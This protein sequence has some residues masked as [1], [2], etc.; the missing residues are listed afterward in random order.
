MLVALASLS[1]SS[2]AD[3]Q[4]DFS[5]SNGNPNGA[6]SYGT[7]SS[8]GGSFTAFTWTQTS[9]LGSANFDGWYAGPN[10]LPG[11]YKLLSGDIFGANG[12]D[13]FIAVGEVSLHGGQNG[14]LAAVRYTVPAAGIFN[15]TG[16]FASGDSAT[17]VFGRI[18]G[19]VVRNGN[20]LWSA[21][22]T[23]NTETFALGA[24]SLNA[25][26]T[27]DIVVGIGQDTYNFDS[28]PVNLAVTPVPEPAT[29]AA[30]GLG[31]AAVARRRKNR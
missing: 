11:A 3:L 2:L 26:D 6:W 20:I 24:V 7:L 17:P 8:I 27:I 23:L 31:L 5:T 14:E 9:S 1:A 28:T 25:G 4:S 13:G 10:S 12:G 21:L 15:L 18:D 19:Y 22:N 29:L 30:L 16:Y